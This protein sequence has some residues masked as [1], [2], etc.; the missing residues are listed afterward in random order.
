M[1]PPIPRD[2]FKGFPPDLSDNTEA[3]TSRLLQN[4]MEVHLCYHHHQSGGFRL[5]MSR[6]S[7]QRKAYITHAFAFC[8][9][10]YYLLRISCP[11]SFHRNWLNVRNNTLFSI[12]THFCI[13]YTIIHSRNMDCVFHQLW[14]IVI[15]TG[16]SCVLSKCTWSTFEILII[17]YLK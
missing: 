1:Q 12:N 9:M 3:S 2:A 17:N 13:I 14:W 4:W 6:P 10:L 15:N 16:M 7:L 8:F 11:D 5:K